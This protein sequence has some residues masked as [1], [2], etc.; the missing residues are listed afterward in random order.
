M[1]W[2]GMTEQEP[3]R[4]RVLIVAGGVLSAAGVAALSWASRARSPWWFSA[5]IGT[6]FVLLLAIAVVLVSVIVRAGVHGLR[7]VHARPMR[8][9]RSSNRFGVAPVVSPGLIA[10][11]Q[12]MFSGLILATLLLGPWRRIEHSDPAL[13]TLNIVMT[14][15]VVVI[16][17]LTVA[18]GFFAWRGFVVDLTKAGVRWRGPLFSRVVPWEALE[19]GG[20]P[21]PQLT[22]TR[23]HLAVVRPELVV[24]RGWA[25][26]FGPRLR[27]VVPLQVDVHPWFLADAIRW[28]AEHPN[29]RDA[30]GTDAEHQR[31]IAELTTP[32]RDYQRAAATA[33]QRPPRPMVVGIAARLTWAG[34]VLGLLA[35]AAD[36]AVAIVF[37]DQ[38]AAAERAIEAGAPRI[39]GEPVGDA[40]LTAADSAMAWAIG[41]L[42]LASV[43]GVLAIVLVRASARGSDPAR[44]GLVVLCGLVAAWAICPV[45]PPSLILTD[46]P[47]APVV[48]A[49]VL[50]LWL[51]QRGVTLIL[52]AAVVVLLLL[53][54]AN[55]YFRPNV[56]ERT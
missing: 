12:I 55:Q 29:D 52:A 56:V 9:V 51:L 14:T 46:T 36:L 11:L 48:G 42:V 50:T 33:G 25:L 23:L 40:I 34:V 13:S 27:P 41:A 54:S 7:N 31:L 39:S 43:A 16:M 49:G 8:L 38:L 17:V 37:N 24:Q 22:A 35:A 1:T 2:R 19:P 32:Q 28:Y 15:M 6:W 30:I 53:P 4:S 18:I 45:G 3:S 47:D 10:M 21:R 26:G 44:I 5:L 20:P